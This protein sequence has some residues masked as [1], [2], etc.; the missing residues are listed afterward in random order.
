M[1]TRAGPDLW[2]VI[3]AKCCL[4]GGGLSPRTII[5]AVTSQLCRITSRHFTSGYVTSAYVRRH[6][7]RHLVIWPSNVI[8]VI[9]TPALVVGPMELEGDNGR[10]DGV[11][12]SLNI[13]AQGGFVKV[14]NSVPVYHPHLIS[15]GRWIRFHLCY[16]F[17][18]KRKN[19]RTQLVK[20]MMSKWVYSYRKPLP[21]I[22]H[23]MKVLNPSII[24]IIFTRVNVY[25]QEWHFLKNCEIYYCLTNPHLKF[26]SCPYSLRVLYNNP[27]VEG[28]PPPPGAP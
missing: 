12:G 4:T 7:K 27:S 25:C 9:Q 20:R 8:N 1:W 14:V 24:M 11:R 16:G 15:I 19:Y 28:A 3:N 10:P 21:F 13:Q 18:I 17:W 22:G 23:D 2:V 26:F 6:G 5:A